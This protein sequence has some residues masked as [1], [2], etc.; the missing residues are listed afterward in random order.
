VTYLI[1]IPAAISHIVSG[2]ATSLHFSINSSDQQYAGPYTIKIKALT[3]GTTFLDNATITI[4]LLLKKA[5]INLEKSFIPDQ[6]FYVKDDEFSFGFQEFIVTGTTNYEMVYTVSQV[7][8][9]SSGEGNDL[10][11]PE[12]V[13]FDGDRGKFTVRR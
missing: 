13:E 11:L 8:P 9:K 1:E 3:D 2:D 6:N 4:T 7:N 5:K 12:S 10:D